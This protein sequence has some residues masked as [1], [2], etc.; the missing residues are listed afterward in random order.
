MGGGSVTDAESIESVGSSA[1][2]MAARKSLLMQPKLMGSAPNTES[3]TSSP[4]LARSN[5]AR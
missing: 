5:S 1:S 4:R 3:P 2:N